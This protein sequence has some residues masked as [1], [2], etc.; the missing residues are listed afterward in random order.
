MLDIFT[1]EIKSGN[2]LCGTHADKL[3]WRWLLTLANIHTFRE[4]FLKA[5][6]WYASPNMQHTPACG[7]DTSSSRSWG[8]ILIHGWFM[9]SAAD[10]L[11]PAST[12]RSRDTKSAACGEKRARALASYWPALIRLTVSW[13]DDPMNGWCFVSRKKRQ[14]P[15]DHMSAF[16]P[17]DTCWTTSGAP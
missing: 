13:G 7:A 4:G 14:T 12:V 11:R 6:P 16:I 10:I 2:I 1:K 9:A 15:S 17:Q 8:P 5:L 3:A